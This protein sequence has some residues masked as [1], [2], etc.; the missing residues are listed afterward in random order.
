MV[1][2]SLD[3][4]GLEESALD[5]YP[6]QF[7][8]GQKQRISI[9]RALIL[10]PRFLV[11]DEP[12]SSLDVSVQAQILFLLKKLQ[13]ERNLTMVFISHNLSVVEYLCNKV[14]VMEGGRIIETGSTSQIFATAE[15]AYTQRLIEAV[16][17][18]NTVDLH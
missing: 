8:G 16:P 11:A 4:V 9:A 14:A 10:N 2:E 17:S 6:S 12:V 15:Q 18:I 13:R 1:K 5:K 3:W 7:S